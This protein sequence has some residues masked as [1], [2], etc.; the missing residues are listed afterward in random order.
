[1]SFKS[2]SPSASATQMRGSPTCSQRARS[3]MCSKAGSTGCSQSS[4]RPDKPGGSGDTFVVSTNG[5]DEVAAWHDGQGQAI[6]FTQAQ[7][8][9]F[10][11]VTAS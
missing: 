5:Q 2:K 6:G 1:M 4:H 7:A 3:K 9:G 8:N 11:I 10:T